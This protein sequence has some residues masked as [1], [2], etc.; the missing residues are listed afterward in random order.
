M[1]NHRLSIHA[2]LVVAGLFQGCNNTAND[3]P[4]TS[5]DTNNDSTVVADDTN[6]NFLNLEEAT[7]VSGSVVGNVLK[8]GDIVV[9]DGKTTSTNDF[10]FPDV[11]N[12][13]ADGNADWVLVIKDEPIPNQSS[14]R[15]LISGT[16]VA[17]KMGDAVTIRYDMFS[18]STGELVDSTQNLEQKNLTVTAGDLATGNPVPI[19]LNNAL[20]NRKEGTRLQVIFPRLM[21]DLPPY[22]NRFDAYVL[23]V[24]IDVVAKSS[25][26]S[27]AANF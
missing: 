2:L 23:I 4:V 6:I 18:W 10:S 9:A 16:G 24:D 20:L 12:K 17:V 26:S 25:D 19:E 21:R 22:L 15:E 1:R 11:M 27:T 8:Q 14:R 5:S 13:K 7:A 3:Q